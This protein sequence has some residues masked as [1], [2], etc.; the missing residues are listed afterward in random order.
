MGEKSAA[1]NTQAAIALVTAAISSGEADGQTMDNALAS[2]VFNQYA[3]DD[4][5]VERIVS[6]FIQLSTVL[7]TQIEHLNGVTPAETLR[8][9][10]E[11]MATVD[12]DW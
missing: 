8:W 7:L 2:E 5:G 11:V 4:G 10:A 3:T 12:G 1:E 6:G 9:V